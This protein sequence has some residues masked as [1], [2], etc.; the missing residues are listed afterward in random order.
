MAVAESLAN[1]K[2]FNQ[3]DDKLQFVSGY[4]KRPE[5]FGY[6][7]SL[8]YDPVKTVT[9]PHHAAWLVHQRRDRCQSNDSAMQKKSKKPIIIIKTAHPIHHI[10]AS[11]LKQNGISSHKINADT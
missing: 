9:L 11:S 10:Q 2:G 7:S 1:C 4:E 5:W 6:A 3:K 8:F